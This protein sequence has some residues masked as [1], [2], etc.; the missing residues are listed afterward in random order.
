LIIGVFFNPLIIYTNSLILVKI[1]A[2]TVLFISERCNIFYVG[3]IKV[4]PGSFCVCLSFKGGWLGLLV[5]EAVGCSLFFG[6]GVRL[7]C[8]LVGVSFT[9][10]VMDLA[11]PLQE[12]M[13]FAAAK[14]GRKC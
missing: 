5:L 6:V 10:Y 7:F 14:N 3:T 9:L 12:F 13:S 1:M 2:H 8:F 11:K 4:S